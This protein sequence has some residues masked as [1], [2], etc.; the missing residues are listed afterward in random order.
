MCVCVCVYMY[1][2]IHIHIYIMIDSN[3]HGTRPPHARQS[4]LLDHRGSV[5]PP[6]IVVKIVV[7]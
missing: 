2:Y 5:A 6:S 3:L 1:M 7:K 4:A